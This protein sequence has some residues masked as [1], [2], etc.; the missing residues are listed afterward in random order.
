MKHEKIY[1]IPL[2]DAFDTDCECAL[3]ELESALE[4]KNVEFCL[5]PAMMKPEFRIDTNNTGF[6]RH[7][8]GMMLK[9]TNKLPLALVLDT[10]FNTISEIFSSRKGISKAPDIDSIINRLNELNHSC[11]ICNFINE[12]MDK[13]INVVLYMWLT[14]DGFK[15]KIANS[16]GFCIKHFLML[17]KKAKSELRKKDANVFCADILKLQQ[18]EFKRVNDDIYWFTQKFDYKNADADWKNSKDA[19]QRGSAKLWGYLE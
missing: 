4:K 10:H 13:Y 3:C 5:G 2:N 17:L 15:K 16:K 14:D 19:P 11:I 12:V 8:L 1:E 6:C 18:Q 9:E 7:H